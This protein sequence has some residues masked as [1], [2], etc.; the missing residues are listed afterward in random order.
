M[1]VSRW[2]GS[3]LVGLVGKTQVVSLIM[4][5]AELECGIMVHDDK[6]K[7]SVAVQVW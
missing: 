3:A 5:M 6:E 4:R 7:M 2:V 1:S